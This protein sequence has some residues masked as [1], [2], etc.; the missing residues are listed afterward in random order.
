MP[1]PSARNLNRYRRHLL[2]NFAFATT[3]VFAALGAGTVG[4]HVTEGLP[5]VDALLC[6]AMILTGMGPTAT[7][8]TTAGK[9]FA[10]AYALFSGVFFLTMAALVIGPLVHYLLRRLHLTL[11]HE[12]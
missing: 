8:H 12:S 1:N 7:L 9:L 10:T 3:M 11:E 4:Y 2:R 5:W 6:A